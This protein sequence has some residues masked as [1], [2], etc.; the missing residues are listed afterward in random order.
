[1]QDQEMK[2]RWGLRR[3]GTSD[4]R[5]GTHAAEEDGASGAR[6]TDGRGESVK[7]RHTLWRAVR[8]RERQT[9]SEGRMSG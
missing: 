3:K 7:W 6:H 4:R 5:R 2:V 1:M 8:R 9:D